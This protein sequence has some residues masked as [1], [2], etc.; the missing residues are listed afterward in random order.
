MDKNNKLQSLVKLIGC[1]VSNE[2]GKNKN[3]DVINT[4]LVQGTGKI[5][6]FISEDGFTLRAIH[7]S[8]LDKPPKK[9]YAL[10]EMEDKKIIKIP[11]SSLISS[12]NKAQH[13]QD[14]EEG[15][16]PKEKTK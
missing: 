15:N 13:A 8:H 14:S 9:L 16:A 2:S 3:D 1:V 11:A 5:T 10:I 4:N 6:E 7:L 12:T